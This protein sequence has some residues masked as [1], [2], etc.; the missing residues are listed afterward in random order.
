MFSSS[1]TD[2]SM[3]RFVPSISRAC[4]TIGPDSGTENN[5]TKPKVAQSDRIAPRASLY[6]RIGKIVCIS[7]D[8]RRKRA[9]DLPVMTERINNA[10]QA[11][12]IF[13]SH[14][15]HLS[16]ARRDGLCV[17]RRGVFHN[18][19]HSNRASAKQFGAEVEV[20]RG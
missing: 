2:P 19:E 4:W 10:P 20:L 7:D 14:R 9:A 6:R 5:S 17:D 3:M 15:R 18:Q 8:L 12:A 13:V 16:C 11:P 1:L